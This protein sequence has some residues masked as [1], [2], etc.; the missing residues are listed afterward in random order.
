MIFLK[1]VI[2]I[3]IEVLHYIQTE[4]ISS[5]N[6]VATKSGDPPP[7]LIL[8]VYWQFMGGKSFSIW[9]EQPKYVTLNSCTTCADVAVSL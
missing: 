4:K 2:C 7:N 5:S 1:Y 6:I 9:S 3:K 8:L